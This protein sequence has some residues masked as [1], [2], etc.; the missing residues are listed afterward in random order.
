[1]HD[2]VGHYNRF[3]IF[4]LTV[5]RAEMTPLKFHGSVEE[6]VDVPELN[7]SRR[8]A[9]APSRGARRGGRRA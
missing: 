9:K 8:T 5:N 4:Q 6:R 3:D 1:M 2:I 7:A